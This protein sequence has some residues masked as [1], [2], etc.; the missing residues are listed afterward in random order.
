MRSAAAAAA[1]YLAAIML[2][3]CQKPERARPTDEQVL[4]AA[5]PQLAAMD[6][7]MDRVMSEALIKAWLATIRRGEREP[8]AR[9]LTK[10]E[11]RV[12]SACGNTPACAV[13]RVS[14]ILAGNPRSVVYRPVVRGD[15]T[16][17]NVAAT[18]FEDPAMR[19]AEILVTIDISEE[20]DIAFRELGVS[21]VAAAD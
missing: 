1:A 18:D 15:R 9:E 11:I 16:W 4:E 13:A 7:E 14:E 3:G 19:T 6:D 2:S 21:L 5:A 8:A 12:D 20:G 10:A 17:V